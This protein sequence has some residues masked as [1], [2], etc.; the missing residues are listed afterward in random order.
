[1]KCPGCER[2]KRIAEIIV[3]D[4]EAMLAKIR[5]V[6]AEEQVPRKSK[7]SLEEMRELVEV[8]AEGRMVAYAQGNPSLLYRAVRE[9][10]EIRE[11]EEETARFAAAPEGTRPPMDHWQRPVD[12]KG[13]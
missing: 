3:Q 10:I 13:K 5:A 2:W 12:S 11:R 7:L 8:A 6:L 4:R 1:M 9:L